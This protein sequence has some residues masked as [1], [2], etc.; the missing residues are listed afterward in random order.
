MHISYYNIVLAVVIHCCMNDNYEIKINMHTE[1]LQKENPT[2]K[3]IYTNVV[4]LCFKLKFEMLSKKED[5]GG[6]KG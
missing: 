5:S 1:S 6:K 4:F 2:H 3:V